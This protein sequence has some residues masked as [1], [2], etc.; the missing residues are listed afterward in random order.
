MSSSFSS[1][2]SSSELPY[3]C[4][5]CGDDFRFSSVPELRAHLVSRHTYE[6]L[7]VL[8]QARVRSS[9]PGAL[10]PLPGPAVAQTQSSS[11]GMEPRSLPLPLAC[12]DL[13]SS[14]ASIRLLREMFTTTGPSTSAGLPA[15]PSTALALPG[16]LEPFWGKNVELE[17]GMAVRIGLEE[18]LG[19]GL[20]RK[21][22]RTFAEVE[23]RVNQRLSRLKVELQKRE[24]ELEQQR[25]DR[26]RLRG[27]KQEVEDRAAYL[28]RQVSAAME[29]MEQLKKDLEGKEK[30]LSERQQEMV[31]IEHFLRETAEKEARAKAKL[32]A[33]IEMLLERA[34][35]A[36][37]HLLLLN[38]HTHHNHYTNSD[39]YIHADSYGSVNIRGGRSL[40][41]SVDD[42]LHN[43]MQETIGNRRSYSVSGSCR[44][45]EQLYSHHHYSG[46]S[47]RMRTLSLGSGGW[48]VEGGLV[49][50]P[51]HHYA[52]PWGQQRGGDRRRERI[53]AGESGRWGMTW[54]KR[55]RRHHSTEEEEE[56]DEVDDEEEEGLW[57]SAELRRLVFARTHTPGSD[58]LSSVPSSPS[59]RHGERGLGP[60]ALRLRAGLFCVF[61]YLDVRSLLRVAE[62]CSDW[63]FVARH[64]AVWT[65]LHLENSRISAEFLITLSQWCT[66]TQTVVLNNLKPR[67][68]R[69]NE[70][71]EDYHRNIRGSVEPGVEALLRSAGGSLLHLSVSQCPHILT[72]RTLWLASC[73]C[74]NLSALTYRSSSDPLGQEVLWA[75][76]AGCR[77]ISSLQVAPAHP[78]QQP[79][80]FGNRCLQTIGR[81]WPHLSSLSVGGASCDTQ[82]L[83]GVVRSCSKLQ[84]LELERITDLGLQAAT[85]LCEAGLKTLHTLILTHTPVS[86][87]AILHFHSVCA[88]IRSIVVQVSAADYFEEPDTQE[89]QH[90]FGEILSTLKVLQNRPG[91][92]DILQVKVDGS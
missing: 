25:L 81:C 34:D 17:L 27:E 24:A 2:S 1:A 15:D 92:C 6:T 55:P 73:Y 72:D 89:A 31:D 77:N 53:R 45:G 33:F 19:L 49:H 79:T 11:L 47:G 41:G 39:T 46:L 59:C 4:P 35:R 52:S 10:L 5:R 61:P 88:N 51:P 76:G 20:D 69:T 38:T 3:F 54:N 85:Q 36:E 40:D 42:I 60:D 67:S 80:R 29:M 43:K 50:L 65:R 12:L 44:L 21:I 58:V 56:E 57:S 87:Q 37:R 13:A 84:L 18:R 63:R 23:E 86:G 30:E 62:V 28:S 83:V 74:R 78:C 64:P 14:S 8:S 7:L 91:L 66:Q 70:T 48:D 22:T 90:L 68:R 71:R 26:E 9:R 75:L 82:G 32:Q 16:S